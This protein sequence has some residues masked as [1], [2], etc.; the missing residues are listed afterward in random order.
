MEGMATIGGERAR[1]ISVPAPPAEDPRAMA[2]LLGVLFVGAA[3]LGAITLLLPHPRAF[4]DSALFGNCAVAAFAGLGI[5][6]AAGRLP[7]WSLMVCVAFG[8]LAITSAIYYSQEPS[9]YYSFF[10]LWSTLYSFYF[11]GRFRGLVQ[12]AVIA[13]CYAWVLNQVPSV[14]P[15][16]VWLTT[17]GSLIV[18]GLLVDLLARRLRD[19][20]AESS[21][22]ARAL[23]AV[24]SVAR[25]LALRTTAESAALATC[26]AAAE[27]TGATGAALWQ[28]TSDTSGLEATAATDPEL[29]GAVVLLIGEPS[30][31]LRAFNTRKPFFVADARESAEV[32]P[33]LVEKLGV[34]SVLFQP[35]M[36]DGSP[37]GVL[38]IYWDEP[39]PILPQEV[40]QVVALLSAEVSI[41]IDRAELLS[42]LERA[43]RTDDLTGLPNRRAWDEY[44]ERELAH[45]KRLDTRLCVGILDLDHFKE[46]NDRHGHQAGDRFLKQAAAVW[47]T[48]IRET[49]LIA[50]HGGEEFAIALLDC[51]LHEAVDLLDQIREETPEGESSSVGLVAWNGSEDEAELVA[52]ADAALYAAKNAG[53]DQVFVA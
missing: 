24:G 3:V 1:T 43:A 21:K 28:P 12:M 50:R 2:L 22:Q 37:I 7:R 16:T 45:A 51:Q 49:D 9:A 35:I 19:R 26:E 34:A 29:V 10:F 36:R 40:D 52:R 32:N 47:Q 42:R 8:S 18:A 39:V 25:E 20:E 13:A 11:F 14:T 41:A 23:A 48:R 33:E 31:A 17:I 38:T 6:A 5:L 4:N 46:Y 30:G 44:L 27:V 53:R 15:V